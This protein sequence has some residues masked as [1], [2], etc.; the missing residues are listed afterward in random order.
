[1]PTIA[2][3]NQR[4]PCCDS[5]R[6]SDLKALYEG[7]EAFEKKLPKFLP[8][9]EREPLARYEL[10]KKEYHY[11]NYIGPIVD[12]FASLLFTARPQPVAK[13]PESDD[14]ETD[15]GDYYNDFRDDCDRTGTD[16][17]SFFKAA[18]TKA[19]VE[20]KAWIR[21][22]HPDGTESA[23]DK[24]QFDKL[25]LGDAWIK[26]LEYD[27]VLDWEYDDEDNLLW[28][29][30]HKREARRDGPAGDR[31]EITE[32]WQYLTPEDVETFAISYDKDRPPQ[33]EQPV[34]SL[35][36]VSHRFERV[37]LVC[38]D[39]PPGLWLAKRLKTPQL[40]HF[41][42]SNGQSWSL[43]AT[44]YA[45]PVAKVADPEEFSKTIMG[46]G[47]GVIIGIEESWEWEAPPADHF[48][49]LDTEIKSQKDEIFR[50][51]HQMALGVENNSAAV[52]RSAESKAT[53]AQSTR[54]MLVAFA[55]EVKEEM[56]R[57]YNAISVSRGDEY[58]W[59]IAGLDE[60]ATSDLMGFLEALTLIQAAGGIPSKTANVQ[61]KTRVAEGFLPD[62]DQETR[63][64][65]RKEIEDEIQNAPDPA[66]AEIDQMVRM[67]T[68]LAGIDGATPPKPGQPKPPSG[69]K[70]KKAFGG[71]NRSAPPAAKKA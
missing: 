43:S 25:K 30:T 51:A 10:R 68:A 40:A 52:G 55:K 35:G 3:L 39:F 70:P 13:K 18:F 57:V 27:E 8:R 54:V 42:A 61:I 62:I 44:C 15:P 34:P 29:I 5:E 63:A 60:F 33:P 9:R 50:I 7:E 11:R 31:K 23:T 12:Y 19:M 14:P 20:G 41:R 56:E 65:I 4:H 46:A 67:H 45:M 66:D 6:V 71:G 36:V 47:Y 26:P 32:T 28:A 24:A 64:T 21:L 37:P 53:D 22:Y 48:L 2:Q 59:T 69:T 17:D 49:A 16:I 38:I 58:T 1:M